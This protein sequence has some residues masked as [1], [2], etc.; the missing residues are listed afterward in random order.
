MKP[1]S[2]PCSTPEDSLTLCWLSRRKPPTATPATADPPITTNSPAASSKVDRA[3][4]TP[5]SFAPR[6]RFS[7]R[8]PSLG[9]RWLSGPQRRGSADYTC[10]TDELPHAVPAARDDRYP[11]P[12]SSADGGE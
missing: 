2:A 12:D 1:S 10:P 11:A 4:S 6:R 7:G 9:S 8:L 3:K 5:S